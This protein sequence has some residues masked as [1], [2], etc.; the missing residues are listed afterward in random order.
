[1][2][3]RPKILLLLFLV[4]MVLP[5]A[6]LPSDNQGLYISG[7]VTGLSTRCIN[8]EPVP[9]IGVYLQIRNDGDVPVIL[10][11]PTFSFEVRVFFDEIGST[12]ADK[13]TGLEALRLNPYLK[14]PFGRSTTDDY[15]HM[16]PYFRRIDKPEPPSESTF[17]L[18]P[19]RSYEF[20]D[21]IWVKGGFH[22]PERPIP[23]GERYEGIK[24]LYNWVKPIP[25]HPSFRLEYRMSPKK[26]RQPEDLFRRFRDRWRDTGNFLLDSSGD[27]FYRT[28]AIAL[29]LER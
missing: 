5:A 27:V 2:T 21:T 26:Y 17:I 29:P 11:T 28:E 22:L 16:S 14:N 15:D 1:M 6:G 4:T 25:E 13:R 23:D 12:T 9:Q 18:E 3:S 7:S 24:C 8:D 10:L 19:G 20:R